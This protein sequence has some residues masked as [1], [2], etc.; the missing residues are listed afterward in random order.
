MEN[1]YDFNNLVTI[2][3]EGSATPEEIANAFTKNLNAAST[4]AAK[5]TAW[6]ST[7]SE[8]VANWNYLIDLY[9]D[10][11]ELPEDCDIS[12]FYLSEDEAEDMVVS[13]IKSCVAL[14]HVKSDINKFAKHLS[15]KDRKLSEDDRE[16]FYKVMH[17]FFKTIGI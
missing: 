2:L 8:F 11:H 9:W 16:D 3:R 4:E 15:D 5:P 6:E 13:S 14:L 7:I 17:N 10:E 1:T 12:K